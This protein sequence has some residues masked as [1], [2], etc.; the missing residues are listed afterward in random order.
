ME[1][2]ITAHAMQRLQE[3]RITTADLESALT[4]R[5][6]TPMPGEPGT[7][8]IRGY[9]AGGRILK[10]CVDAADEARIITAAWP[11]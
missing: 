8:W 2:R 11:D 3:R 10:V 9:A 4:R 7:V 6:G 5:I 1:L